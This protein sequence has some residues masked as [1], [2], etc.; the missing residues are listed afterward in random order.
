MDLGEHKELWLVRHGET[1][2]L[3]RGL[4]QG[5]TNIGLNASGRRQMELLGLRLREGGV[6]FD[7]FWSSDLERAKESA[8]ILQRF[9]LLPPR[10]QLDARLREVDPGK[11][12]G[13][14]E[15]EILRR[16][17]EALRELIQNPWEG[18]RPQGES[19]AQVAARVGEFLADLP[20]GKH[21][22]VTHE[23][24]L[25][26]LLV[27]PLGLG[28]GCLSR[29]FL[30]PSSLTKVLLPERVLLSLG[31]V[32]HLERKGGFQEEGDKDAPAAWE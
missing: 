7:G 10:L 18:K 1:P 9:L 15:E 22:V 8:L 13:L 14:R 23:G 26:A 30:L 20:P 2:W 28:K 16:Y 19:L 25:K 29:V 32:A 17:P 4:V 21:L 6:L 31:D 11:F 27:G 24:W 3:R 5:H 12:V